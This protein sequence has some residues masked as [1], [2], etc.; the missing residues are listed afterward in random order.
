MQR[1]VREAAA[2]QGFRTVPR[3]L[4][5]TEGRSGEETGR[6]SRAGRE[7]ASRGRSVVSDSLAEFSRP[8]Y[9]SG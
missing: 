1:G 9:W 8:G 4:E 2:E 3:V 7:R 5:T 6:G